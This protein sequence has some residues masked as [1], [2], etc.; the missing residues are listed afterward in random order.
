M[1]R[2]VPTTLRVLKRDEVK[3]LLAA[4]ND[5][6][7]DKTWLVTA[8]ATG[9]RRGE[10]LALHW[11]DIDLEQGI[12][13]GR[14]MVDDAGKLS[15]PKTGHRAFALPG[16]LIAILQQHRRSQDTIKQVMGVAWRENDLVFASPSGGLLNAAALSRSLDEIAAQAGIAPVRFHALRRTACFLMLSAGI[17]P[18]VV[19]AILGIHRIASPLARLSPLSFAMHREAAAKLDA[20]FRD[21]LPPALIPKTSA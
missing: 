15:E 10:L 17:P 11:A 13:A 7:P 19:Q 1:T 21:M 12:L 4:V 9:L 3:R 8:L 16:L 14:R 18:A 2:S 6:S 20:A 5:H